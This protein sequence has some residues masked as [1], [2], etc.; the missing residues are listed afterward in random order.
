MRQ[1]LPRLATLE[2]EGF[3]PSALELLRYTKDVETL[4]FQEGFEES[5]VYAVSLGL[6]LN[7]L[8]TLTIN[9]HGRSSSALCAVLTRQPV[10]LATLVL[11][12]PEHLDL[13]ILSAHLS[14]LP[15]LR[16]IFILP[17]TSTPQD[18]IYAQIDLSK[19]SITHLTVDS[20]PSTALLERL[21]LTLHTIEVSTKAALHAVDWEDA[22][23]WK[24]RHAPAL[25]L[26]T[27]KFKPSP[28]L[29][30][31]PEEFLDRLD[32]YSIE[33]SRC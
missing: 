15:L 17:S 5:N 33:I 14:S 8:K 31:D 2:L 1:L 22:L 19:S 30:W 23:G 28:G 11:H 12:R 27:V 3:I 20:W 9:G 10:Q 18:P 25:K 24:R 32:G 16:H 6:S 29:D 4:T 7:K 26:L 13:I 21:P